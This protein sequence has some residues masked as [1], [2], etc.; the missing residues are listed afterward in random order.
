MVYYEIKRF[1]VTYNKNKGDKTMT[2][3]RV[4]NEDTGVYFFEFGEEKT[5]GALTSGTR[6]LVTAI[7]TSSSTIP[8]GLKVGDIFLANE[9]TAIT[10]GDGDKVKP[11]TMTKFC[12]FQNVDGTFDRE[13]VDVT[14]L[15]DKI[16][17]YR[18]GRL[19]LELS[20][21]LV[22][23]TS[24]DNAETATDIVLGNLLEMLDEQSDGTYNRSTVGEPVNIALVLTEGIVGAAVKDLT[25]YTPAMITSGGFSG[26]TNAA[27]TADVSLS[28]TTGDFE[29]QI[30]KE[31]RYVA[32]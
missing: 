28:V 2:L 5:T 22:I 19:T 26:G 27:K 6:Y 32:A 15:C 18:A 3:K 16:S 23:E 11:L 1:H 17:T 12:G 25:L 30:V 10:L 31:K 14:A 29:P 21:T 7:A 9:S 8:S 20:G 13:Q 4:I 24:T